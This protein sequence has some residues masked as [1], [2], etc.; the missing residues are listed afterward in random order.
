MKCSSQQFYSLV[1]NLLD[2]ISAMPLTKFHSFKQ[3]KEDYEKHQ[4]LLYEVSFRKF[5]NE[6][7]ERDNLKEN[8]KNVKG[9]YFLSV[10]KKTP[11]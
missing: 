3:S 4:N 10:L 8:I 2:E 7:Q 1:T 5:Q 9:R 6:F 11:F